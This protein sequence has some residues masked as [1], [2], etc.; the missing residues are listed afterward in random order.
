MAS[1]NSLISGSAMMVLV[2]VGLL[3][4][5][6]FFAIGLITKSILSIVGIVLIGLGGYFS[7]G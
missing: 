4:V 1:Y 6:W 2:G 3:I 7:R 5:P